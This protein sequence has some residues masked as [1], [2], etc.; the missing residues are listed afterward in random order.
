MNSIQHMYWS[1]IISAIILWVNKCNMFNISIFRM[2]KDAWLKIEREFNC[3]SIETPRTADILKNK[4]INL[5]R[6]VKKQYAEE[7][8]YHRGTGGG[9]SKSF[10]ASS[11]AVSIGEM[12]QNK[13]TG[14]MPIYDSDAFN[15]GTSDILEIDVSINKEIID[16]HIIFMPD[17]IF[18]MEHAT[19]NLEES[20]TSG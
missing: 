3:Q 11:A 15:E 16:D 4:Y 13:M 7:K 20:K 9:P 6:K 12:L 2:K 8:V 18:D 5:K 14:E 10:L 1:T 17:D 19:D